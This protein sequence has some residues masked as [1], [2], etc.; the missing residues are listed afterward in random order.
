MN[1]KYAITLNTTKNLRS[2]K[3]SFFI[4]S[5]E[6]GLFW[7]GSI[8]KVACTVYGGMYN[9]STSRWFVSCFMPVLRHLN[10]LSSSEESEEEKALIFWSPSKM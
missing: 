3:W 4:S 5:V 8:F 10:N 1:R 9:K 6:I 2:Y 7:M